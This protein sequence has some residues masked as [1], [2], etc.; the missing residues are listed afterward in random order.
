M[1]A[2]ISDHIKQDLIMRINSGK[3]PPT[4]LSIP[5]LAKHYR[6]SFSP[7]REALRGLIEEGVVI[8]GE[9]KRLRL[10]PKLRPDGTPDVEPPSL[11]PNHTAEL[12]KRVAADLIARSLRRETGYLREDAVIQTYGVSRTL[13]RQI[14]SRLVGR[15][16]L[17][18]VPRCG[19]RVRALDE[20]D[21]DEYL[22]VREMMELKA[23]ELAAPH[24][25]EADLRRMFA[26]NAAGGKGKEPLLDNSLHRYIID[27][28][29]NSYIRD[30][31][32]R[33]GAYYTTVFDFAVPE[34]KVVEG[35]ARQHRA[36]LKALIDR[37]WA[38]AGK[39]LVQH[40]RD[41]RPTVK[42][43]MRRLEAERGANGSG[44]GKPDEV[45]GRGRPKAGGAA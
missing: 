9:N 35:M 2:T 10:P 13:I 16:L 19:W 27:R 38:R 1:W 24:M 42:E 28:S 34:T 12:E 25:V 8:K 4:D 30:F 20:A 39:A 23:L 15:G 45:K 44:D 5:A 22:V 41:Q 29:G 26:G 18:H 36:I 17:E 6:V 40:I 37:D 3:G 32:D 21:L 14:L 43:L 7:V 11:P 33:H 31:F